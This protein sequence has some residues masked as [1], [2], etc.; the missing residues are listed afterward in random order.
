MTAITHGSVAESIFHLLPSP[1]AQQFRKLYSETIHDHHGRSEIEILNSFWREQL[2]QL[3]I[4]TIAERE[5][6]CHTTALSV[7]LNRFET[8]V[9]PVIVEYRLP[10]GEPNVW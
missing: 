7:W 8:Q 9:L 5:C 3:P 4:N 6:L 2:G 10:T 1:L